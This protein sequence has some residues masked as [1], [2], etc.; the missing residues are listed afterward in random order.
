[1]AVTTVFDSNEGEYQRWLKDNPEGY[2]LTTVREIAPIYMSL[3]RASCRMISQYK[4]NMASDAFT[5]RRYIKICSRSSNALVAWIKE[6]NGDGFTKLCSICAPNPEEGVID[7]AESYYSHLYAEVLRSLGESSARKARLELAPR[8]P[9][10]FST[11]TTIFR[12][13]PDVIAE[14]LERANGHCKKCGA[15]A[16]FKRASNGSPYLEVHHIIALAEGGEDS[17]DNAIALC[18]NCHRQLHFGSSSE[19]VGNG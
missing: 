11:T 18:P 14:T 19:S 16:P 10:S 2:V 6:H 1:M 9:E 7:G 15:A 17:V 5:G 8:L 3:H 12:R 13:N 4:K